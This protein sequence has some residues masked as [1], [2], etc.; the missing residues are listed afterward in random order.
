MARRIFGPTEVLRSGQFPFCCLAAG[1]NVPS[2]RWEQALEAAL[3][4]SLAQ[5]PALP[6]R[7]LVLV[8]WSGSMFDTPGA[9]T[10]LNRAD[11]AAVF[12]AALAAWAERAGLVGFGSDS[13]RVE[14]EPGGFVLRA[15]DR[16][17]DLAGT[18]TAKA[19]TRHCSEHDRVVVVTGEQACLA[20]CADTFGAAFSECARLHLEPGRLLCGPR[21]HRFAPSH[22]RRPQ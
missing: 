2:P 3:G 1:R 18:S 4:H 21:S 13:R 20:P 17:Y 12:A 5:V 16:F 9:H 19:V 22:L 14:L 6:G 11:F 7:T 8:D 10:G 15:L